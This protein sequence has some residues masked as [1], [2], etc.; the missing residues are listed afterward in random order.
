MMKRESGYFSGPFF[1]KSNVIPRREGKRLRGGKK[2]KIRGD[3]GER[4]E[5]IH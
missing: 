2:T 3:W 5:I 4:E 1:T